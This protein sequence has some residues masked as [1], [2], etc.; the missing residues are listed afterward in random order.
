MKSLSHISKW[1]YLPLWLFE[2]T[3]F[4]TTSTAILRRKCAVCQAAACQSH[5]CKLWKQRAEG[6]WFFYFYFF[7]HRTRI[8]ELL[9]R[10]INKV[11]KKKEKGKKKLR[12]EQFCSDCEKQSLFSFVSGP[13]D[14]NW[15]RKSNYWGDCPTGIEKLSA[16]GL[17]LRDT[18]GPIHYPGMRSLWQSPANFH[19]HLALPSPSRSL[20]PPTWLLFLPSPSTNPPLNIPGCWPLT[21]GGGGR[22][23]AKQSLLPRVTKLRCAIMFCFPSNWNWLLILQGDKRFWLWRR[24]FI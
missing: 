18:Y 17:G 8:C 15:H 22:A 3:R 10:Q 2:N 16:W 19:Q 11:G 5:G 14:Q 23:V 9:H 4:V 12:I 24:W 13:S 6:A 20:G 21:E 1:K 7:K